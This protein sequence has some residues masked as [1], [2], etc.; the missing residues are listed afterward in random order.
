MNS[1]QIGGIV[2]AVVAAAGGYL[3]AKGMLDAA[4]WQIIA[5]AAATVVVAIWSYKS[6]A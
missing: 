5:G 2:R 6:K 4:T 1:E 3:A